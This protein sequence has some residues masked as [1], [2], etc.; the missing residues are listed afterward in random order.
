LFVTHDIVEAVYLGD[1]VAVMDQGQILLVA[2]VDLPKPRNADC[3]Y[4]KD[5]VAQCQH[6]HATMLGQIVGRT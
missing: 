2:S 6:I 4:N 5:F 1:R 3:R